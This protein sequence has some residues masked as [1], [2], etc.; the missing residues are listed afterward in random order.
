MR[1]VRP[2]AIVVAA[3]MLVCWGGMRAI[4]QQAE[5]PA[6]AQPEG[7]ARPGNVRPAQQPQPEAPARRWADSETADPGS[8]SKLRMV[9]DPVKLSL[10][11]PGGT[12]S[13]FAKALRAAA[14]PKPCNVVVNGEGPEP[15]IPAL[16]FEDVT[17][18]T[19]AAAAT[20]ASSRMGMSV[21]REDEGSA[22]YVFRYETLDRR[23]SRAETEV[24]SLRAMLDAMPED[25][26]GVRVTMT[27]QTVLSAVQSAAEVGDDAVLEPAVIKYHEESSLLFIRGT[28]GQL[29]TVRSAISLLTSDVNRRRS[30]FN[31][32]P[33]RQLETQR[34]K[35][36]VMLR[37]LEDQVAVA[38]TELEQ[39]QKLR[40]AGHAS[41]GH[42]DQAR[43]ELSAKKSQYEQAQL[44]LQQIETEIGI[45]RER[46]AGA[47]GGGNA[48][49][50][51]PAGT[52]R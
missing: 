45:L 5:Q 34:A 46:A 12:L 39:A 52:G 1:A 32:A 7:A 27:P 33:L 18:S 16:E 41:A 38:Q 24:L 35:C 50:A 2:L 4:G 26:S 49:P 28:D 23:A 31:D 43:L 40:A 37:H 19:A 36:A 6:A 10:K 25:P 30:V 17:I 20:R 48:D 13:S 44:D 14:A 8:V 29:K 42:E 47:S 22:I 15:T 3:G 21:V 11:F 9:S 51:K